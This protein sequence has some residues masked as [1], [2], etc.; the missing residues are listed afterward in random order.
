MVDKYSARQ[1]L[2]VAGRWQTKRGAPVRKVFLDRGK[3]V[4]RDV[5]RPSLDDRAVLVAVRY[6]Y[7]SPELERT[8]IAHLG[9]PYALDTLSRKVKQVLSSLRA[10]AAQLVHQKLAGAPQEVVSALGYA[11][12]GEVIAVGSRVRHVRIGDYVACAGAQCA[13][14]A[15]VVLVPDNLAVRVSQHA[16]LKSASV[17]AVGALALQMVRSAS[18][19]LGEYVCVRGLSMLGQ[20]VAQYAKNSGCTVIGIDDRA[21]CREKARE[22]GIDFVVDPAEDVVKEIALIT[23]GQ[24]VDV[25]CLTAFD[26]VSALMQ[27]LIAVTRSHGRIVLGNRDTFLLPAHNKDIDIVFSSSCGLEHDDSSYDIECHD[28]PYAHVR[29]TE[30]RNMRT[31][32]SMI[33]QRQLR[34]DKLL[35]V[36]IS[37]DNIGSGYEQIAQHPFGVIVSYGQTT[38][39][40]EPTNERPPAAFKPARKDLVQVGVLGASP[41]PHNTGAAIV[42]RM[43][44]VAIRAVVDPDITNALYTAQWHGSCDTATASSELLTREGI[45][46]LYISAS[47]GVRADYIG[48]ALKCGKAVFVERPIVM[49]QDACEQLYQAAREHGQTPFCINYHRSFAPFIKKIKSTIAERRTPLMLQYRIN[50]RERWHAQ[51]RAPH[52]RSSIV[53]NLASHV[54]DLFCFLTEARPV[55]VSVESLQARSY[56]LF[57]AHNFSAHISFSD[58]SVCSLLH[59]SLG[60]EKLGAERM[61]L[62]FDGKAI[63]MDDYQSLRGFGLPVSFDEYVPTPDLGQRAIIRKFFDGIKSKN[64]AHLISIDRLHCVARTTALIEQLACQG[65]GSEQLEQQREQ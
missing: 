23:D 36:T 59:T 25:S 12:A 34:V 13:Q 56:D 43:K 26:N 20:L 44:N 1:Y 10:S 38:G 46:A 48:T 50:A 58:G 2:S 30:N 37:V 5:C 51:L 27:Q 60:H 3:I 61:E 55:A 8:D 57:P 15:D 4:L 31:F 33:E 21:E 54:V 62:F 64:S 17:A 35:D 32:V 47:Y 18:I 49:N 45:D 65:G 29:W 14:H 52:G 6:S 40:S 53:T 28:Y 9:K 7:L 42:A 41:Q 63:L 19:Q 24:G 22:M 11:C 16:D 39:G